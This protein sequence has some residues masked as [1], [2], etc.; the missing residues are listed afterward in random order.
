MNNTESVSFAKKTNKVFLSIV[1]FIIAYVVILLIGLCF[2]VLCFIIAFKIVTSFS[3][4]MTYVLAFGIAFT[5]FIVFCYLF[6]F[7]NSGN[8]VKRD[9]LIE[10]D[11]NSEPLLFQ[12]IEE[13]ALEVQCKLPQKVFLSSDVNAAVFIDPSFL[14]LF[15]PVNKNLVIGL[16]LIHTSSDQELKAILAHEF[17][18]FTQKI[19]RI[20]SY[21]Y[22]VNKVL[23][24]MI[25][26]HYSFAEDKMDDSDFFINFR[27]FQDFALV[28]INKIKSILIP[29]YALINKNYLSLSRE[30]EF[31]ADTIAA[32]VVGSETL[33]KALIKIQYADISYLNVLSFYNNRITEKK[34]S[35]NLYR[36]LN[37]VF[38][39]NAKESKLEYKNN[40]PIVEL[41]LLDNYNKSKLVITSQ[42]DSHPSMKDRI[43][44][45]D[46]LNIIKPIK[47][48][49][50]ATKLL[51]NLLELEMQLTDK[52]FSV[53]EVIQNASK[54]DSKEFESE[55]LKSYYEHNS[56]VFKTYFYYNKFEP[57]DI[58]NINDFNQIE[59]IESLFGNE[60]I[61]NV[62]EI[63][64]L[65]FDKVMLNNIAENKM[66][67]KSF[68][69]NDIR[70]KNTEAEKVIEL[71]DEQIEELKF[72]IL[73]ND[74]KIY[75][76]FYSLA[77]LK[78]QEKDLKNLYLEYFTQLNQ[79]ELRKV[80][81]TKIFE[82][83]EFI[84]I[85]YSI[86]YI[87]QAF[88]E[89]KP[90]EEEFKNDITKIVNYPNLSKVIDENILKQYTEYLKRD[91]EY[92]DGKQYKQYE[93]DFLMNAIQNYTFLYY[94]VCHAARKNL[95]DFMENLQ[96]ESE[97][98]AKV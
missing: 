24:T 60:I 7:L 98:D 15:I 4:L 16:G 84:T 59:T 58:E 86:K 1:L 33:K 49:F 34:K 76:Y 94:D 26:E 55:Y 82:A 38:H 30:L 96:I 11:K 62:S 9:H 18:H 87:D 83:A 72:K 46:R 13:T 90:I 75:K 21:V 6:K 81:H 73:Q 20:G 22:Y 25:Y 12:L 78:S 19:S 51:T 89:L 40:L 50:L 31:H 2:V 54:L 48:E 74:I 27:F 95:L 66:Q 57:F 3:M 93:L 37:F 97:S 63:Q 35:D 44:A 43:E 71:I 42:W 32:D 91:Y 10:I 45:L 85:N 17:G 69:Y 79:V 39:F 64:I 68:D 56:K 53:E 28:I 47:E 67:L 52:V 23:Y 29:F 80:L 14:S 70:Y 41:S 77:L 8:K 36:D 5:G 92:F 88:F 65:E 61:A